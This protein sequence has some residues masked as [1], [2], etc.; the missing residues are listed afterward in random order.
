MRR[1]RGAIVVVVGCLA[2][3]APFFAGPLALSL[4]GMLLIVCGALE[5][6]ETFRASDEASLRSDYLSGGLSVFVGVL[7]LNKPQFILKSLA[8]LIGISFVIDGI[9]KIVAALRTHNTQPAWRW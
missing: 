3:A 4:A 6:W 7:L 1:V 5:M 8:L 2:M 9:G